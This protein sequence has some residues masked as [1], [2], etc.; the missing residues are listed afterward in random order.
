M[1]GSDLSAVAKNRH[2][3]ML[4]IACGVVA[5]AFLLQVREDSRVELRL[6]P[7]YPLPETCAT[8]QLFGVDCPGCGLTRSFIH[9][10]RW[11]WRASLAVHR[12]GWLI[13][14]AVLLQIPYRVAA[15]RRGSEFP[16]G[17]TFAIRFGQ[18]LIALLIANWL[19]GLWLLGFR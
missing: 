15:L 3:T 14:A 7:G 8:H 17:R 13:A 4:L 5:F 6:L 18:A 9:L 19:L 11:D 1:S 2:Q 16:L 10:S 12:L